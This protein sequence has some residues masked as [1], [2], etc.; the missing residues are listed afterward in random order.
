MR[1]FK[2]GTTLSGHSTADCEY[3]CTG[4]LD[5]HTINT[6]MTDAARCGEEA[7]VILLNGEYHTTQIVSF[8]TSNYP[9]TLRGESADGAKIV[10]GPTM[11]AGI[12]NVASAQCQN[13][14]L[15]D[16][17][18]IRNGNNVSTNGIVVFRGTRHAIDT[19]TVLDNSAAGNEAQFAIKADGTII[20]DCKLIN[21]KVGVQAA[22]DARSVTIQNC[23]M[24]GSVRPVELANYAYG[25]TI[26]GNTATGYANSDITLGVDAGGVISFGNTGI[27]NMM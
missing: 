27:D 25:V 22:Y 3:L 9:V 13:C 24:V 10:A 15:K 21:N 4:E 20:K 12:L 19:V 8:Y 16:L 11:N 14:T 17:T 2:V 6:A 1:Q 18:I 7:E 23:E 26:Y 5:Q